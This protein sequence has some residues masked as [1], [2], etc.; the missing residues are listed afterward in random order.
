MKRIADSNV[1]VSL[2]VANSNEASTRPWPIPQEA[3]ACCADSLGLLALSGD[4]AREESTSLKG[5]G[6]TIL[7]MEGLYQ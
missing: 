6:F 2:V 3:S 4:A 7:I 5:Q 1:V